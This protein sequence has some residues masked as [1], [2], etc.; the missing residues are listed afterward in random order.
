MTTEKIYLNGRLVEADQACVRVTNPALLHGVGLFETLRAYAGRPFLLER[1][2]ERMQSSAKALNMPL[3]AAMTQIPSAIDEVIE[4]NRLSEARLR[5][6]VTPPGS[7]EADDQPSLIVRGEPTTGYPGGLYERGMT[8]G[9]C[10]RYRQSGADPLAGHKTTSYFPRLV[11]LRD[12]QDRG[13]GEVLWFTP[14]NRLAEGSMT[15][16]FLV[17]AGRLRTP[18]LDTPVLPGVTRAMVIELAI[19]EGLAVD[20]QPCTIN[21]LLD[22]DEVFV[23]NA[24]MEIMPVSQVERRAIGNQRVGEITSRISRAYREL[25]ATPG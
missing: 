11:A 22:A 25:A 16:V 5:F 17:K 12:V 1:H 21:D 24:I 3:S 9:I 8:V 19:K 2:I 13:C 15:N 23:T 20:Q 4:A 10:E 6:T 18:P 7:S 14:D